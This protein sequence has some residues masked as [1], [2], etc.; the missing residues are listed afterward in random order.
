MSG[1]TLVVFYGY[2]NNNLSVSIITKIEVLGFKGNEYE[3]K[4]LNDFI[5]LAN[6]FYVDDNIADKTIE[7]RKIYKIKTP[8]AI[9]AATVLVYG[10]ILISRNVTDF[11]KIEGLKIINPR[12]L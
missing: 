1:N 11:K 2:F 4:K 8:D 9:I 6:I 10:L 7:L 12:E 5:G 3:L